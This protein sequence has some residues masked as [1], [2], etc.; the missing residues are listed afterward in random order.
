MA[1]VVSSTVASSSSTVFSSPQVPEVVVVRTDSGYSG[2]P[3]ATGSGTVVAV[4]CG[5]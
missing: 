1:V 4:V 2:S 3:G 5:G